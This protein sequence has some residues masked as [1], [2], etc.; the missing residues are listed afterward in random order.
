MSE[1]VRVVVADDSPFT[2]QLLTTYF[3][4]SPDF[5]V[6]GTAQDGI[7][8]V[9]LIRELQPDLAT[10]DLDMPGMNGIEVLDTIMRECPLPVVV[11]SG[12]SRQSADMTLLALKH[13]AVDFIFKYVPGVDTDPVG[14]RE[15]I[16]SKA[17]MA[18]QIKV[19]RTIHSYRDMPQVEEQLLLKTPAT[20]G[21]TAQPFFQ[22]NVIV[23]GASTGGPVA[24]RTLVCS[25]PEDFLDAVVIVQHMPPE[26]TRVFA[27]HLE[28][29]ARLKVQEAKS[30]DPIQAGRVLVAPGGYH[31]LFNPDGRV[32]LNQG[33]EIAG[34]RPSIDVTMQSAAQIFGAHT[35][36]IVLTGMGEDGIMGLLSI[37]SK[38]GKTF[39]QDE[40]SSIVY[41]MPQRAIKKG[42]ADYVAPPEEIAK[43]LCSA[44]L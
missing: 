4:A 28:Q 9:K 7:Q 15:E 27:A 20:S 44:S 24:L 10:L 1:P 6:V 8:T 19:V 40:Q 34:H 5:Q 13:G 3:Q 26:F 43:L 31:L 22:G 39:A 36:G 14:L 42:L 12:V 30:G 17:R 18:A 25:L 11:V 29:R 35:R 21:K 2:C 32:E 41:G 38:G 16:I 33:V 23:I 37:R